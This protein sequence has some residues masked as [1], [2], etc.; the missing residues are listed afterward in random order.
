[1][2]TRLPLEDGRIVTIRKASKPDAEQARIYAA[3]GIDLGKVYAPVR[4][5]VKI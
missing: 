4:S 1:M 3:L 2:S 5:E